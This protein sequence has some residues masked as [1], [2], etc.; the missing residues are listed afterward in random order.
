MI[1][2][3]TNQYPP[4]PLVIQKILHQEESE[5]GLGCTL[6]HS[7]TDERKGLKEERAEE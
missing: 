2:D 7:M 3:G 5:D 4:F 6:S 1:Q